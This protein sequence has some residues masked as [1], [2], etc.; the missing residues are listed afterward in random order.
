VIDPRV[1]SPERSTYMTAKKTANPANNSGQMRATMDLGAAVLNLRV[2]RRTVM[3]DC[4][5]VFK[6]VCGAPMTRPGWVRF[7]SI[8]AKFALET[9]K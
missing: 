2:R 3:D 4:P 7:P 9:A 6:T 5:A 1:G 8:P